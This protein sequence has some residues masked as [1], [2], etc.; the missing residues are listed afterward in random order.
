MSSPRDEYTYKKRSGLRTELRD[1]STF[2]DHGD[3]EELAEE[4]ETRHLRRRK[5]N[6]MSMVPPKP[7][8]KVFK[9]VEKKRN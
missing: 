2:A 4:P 8:K 1:T 5:E 9:G 6:Q 7:A 3:K